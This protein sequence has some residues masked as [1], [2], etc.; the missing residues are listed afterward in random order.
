MKTIT[1][2]TEQRAAATLT[3][4]T[5][6]FDLKEGSHLSRGHVVNYLRDAGE[7]DYLASDV[8]RGLQSMGVEVLDAADHGGAQTP[9]SGLDAF[10][11]QSSIVDLDWLAVD[12]EAYR[13]TEVLPVQN[14]DITP[15]LAELWDHTDRSPGIHLVPARPNDPGNTVGVTARRAAQLKA[16]KTVAESIWTTMRQ[17]MTSGKSFAA[18]KDLGFQRL[19]GTDM[20]LTMK[21]ALR[22]HLVQG[23]ERLAAE[24][25]LIGN[26]F[27]VAKDYPDCLKGVPRTVSGSRAPF[28]LAK[29]TCQGCRFAESGNACAQF[30]KQLVVEVPYSEELARRFQVPVASKDP[31]SVKAAL[32]VAFTRKPASHVPLDGKP[33]ERDITAG[34]SAESAAQGLQDKMAREAAALQTAQV[35]ASR[36]EVVAYAKRRLNEG[37]IGPALTKAV[38]DRFQPDL[39]R[40]AFDELKDV[41]AEQGLAGHY[42]VDAS[43]YPNCQRGDV[44][45]LHRVRASLMRQRPSFVLKKQACQGCPCNSEGRCSQLKASLVDKMDYEAWGGRQEA[46]VASVTRGRPRFASN[47]WTDEYGLAAGEVRVAFGDLGPDVGGIGL[48]DSDWDPL[49]RENS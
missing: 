28:V 3:G 21:R 24:E 16:A 45:N 25:G 4:L 35:T 30:K 37:L 18:A 20:P 40:L 19:D 13:E 44:D 11:Q 33:I 32:R 1:A 6:L 14:L 43:A 39:V 41:F 22:K 9:T 12:R 36:A 17:A 8:I 34:I 27:V 48:T 38:V 5:R 10:F 47:E 31:Q 46:L 2:T 23:T 7:P 49:G 42:Y 29:E 26:V 15:D